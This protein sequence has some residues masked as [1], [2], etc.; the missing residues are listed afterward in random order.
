MH[1]YFILFHHN[2]YYRKTVGYSITVSQA[3][4]FHPTQYS[5]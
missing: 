3:V 4:P 2:K 5:L 1:Y